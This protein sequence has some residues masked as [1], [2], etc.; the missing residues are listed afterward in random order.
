[1]GYRSD[2]AITVYGDA[3][4]MVEFETE[5]VKKFLQLP[6]LEQKWLND[7]INAV[8]E[9]NGFT[10]DGYKFYVDHIKWYNDDDIVNFFEELITLAE[11]TG[12][13]AEF[14]RLGEEYDDNETRWYGDDCE[15]RLGV[16]RSISG[17]F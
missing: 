6:E 17:V 9:A 8:P 7:I 1:M 2:V 12:L 10:E 4:A 3:D 5:Y 16:N 13:S 14:I 11:E 15:Y